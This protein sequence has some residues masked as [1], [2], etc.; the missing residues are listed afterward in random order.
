MFPLPSPP[1]TLVVRQLE[2]VSCQ[3]K[4]AITEDH[5]NSKRRSRHADAAPDILAVTQMRYDPNRSLR[6]VLP[7]TRSM[8]RS[9]PADNQAENGP[10]HINCPRCGADN[11][12]WLHLLAPD[13]DLDAAAQSNRL[14]NYWRG[15]NTQE[16]IPIILIGLVLAILMFVTMGAILDSLLNGFLLSLVVIIGGLGVSGLA[17]TEYFRRWRGRFPLAE[18]GVLLGLILGIVNFGAALVLGVAFSKALTIALACVVCAALLAQSST[19]DEWMAL[20]VNQYL[21]QVQPTASNMEQR[22]WLRGGA[23]ILIFALV[24]PV[25]FY[26]LLPIGI[27]NFTEW[28]TAS[29]GGDVTAAVQIGDD[30]TTIVIDGTNPVFLERRRAAI[31]DAIK[32]AGL[33]KRFFVLWAG[34]VGLSSLFALVLSMRALRQFTETAVQQLPPPIFYSIANMTRVVAW[35]AKKALEVPGD[36]GHIQWTRVA[37][38]EAG[39]IDLVGVYAATAVSPAAQPPPKYIPAQE[40]SLTTDAWGRVVMAEI[41]PIR[42]LNLPPISQEG[43][44]GEAFFER[45]SPPISI[46]RE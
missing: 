31:D 5:P 27:T 10:T 26:S 40:Y 23:T 7:E 32:R 1:D 43:Q 41:K 21:R 22:L 45:V 39:G 17:Q 12:N 2:C 28:L 8:P 13:G 9:V 46:A 11:R 3:E 37:R 30:T 29:A 18:T 16:K 6:T 20:R 38:N 15:A 34:S 33:E 35:E 24:I 19:G 36:M 4:F 25:V 14:M 44:L 42:T